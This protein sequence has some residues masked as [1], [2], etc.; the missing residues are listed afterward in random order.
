VNLRSITPMVPS[1][2]DL[3]EGV[4][5]FVDHLGF[6]VT[7]KSDGGAGIARDD[8]AFN[9]VHNDNRAWADNAS[10]SIG[11]SDLAGVYAEYS[12]AP[13]R[14]GPLEI[15]PWGRLEFHMIIPSGVCLQFYEA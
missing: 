2:P 6:T 1:G 15:K 3:A 8:I 9:I 12:K 14:I 5:F 13:A 11:V 7:Y 4:A 10:F